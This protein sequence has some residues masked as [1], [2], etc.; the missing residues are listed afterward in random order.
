[1]LHAPDR[2]AKAS[3]SKAAR[4]LRRWHL[5]PLVRAQPLGFQVSTLFLNHNVRGKKWGARTKHAFRGPCVGEGWHRGSCWLT[6][7]Q[8]RVQ[9]RFE[10]IEALRKKAMMKMSCR[11]LKTFPVI[12]NSQEKRDVTKTHLL[13]VHKNHKAK[14]GRAL[15]L[16][17]SACEV[18]SASCYSCPG[19]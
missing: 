18:W 3:G 17:F 10:R 15:L 7:T 5:Q 2:T 19:R 16:R 13:R 14:R 12:S 6:L 9:R 11:L 1:V 4:C 8:Q